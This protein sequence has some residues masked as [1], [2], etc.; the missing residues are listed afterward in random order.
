MSDW[1]LELV[2]MVEK[3][4]YRR[5]AERRRLEDKMKGRIVMVEECVDAER[6]QV[7]ASFVF[8][9]R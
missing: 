2:V 3:K 5:G 6:L 1:G 8:M 9:R 7:A 4:R